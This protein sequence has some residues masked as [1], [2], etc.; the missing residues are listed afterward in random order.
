[1]GESHRREGDPTTDALGVP[2]RPHHVPWEFD[3]QLLRFVLKPI[4]NSL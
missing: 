2:A 4:Y 1:M 3:V